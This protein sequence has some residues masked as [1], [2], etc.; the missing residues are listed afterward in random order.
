MMT[1]LSCD[2]KNACRSNPLAAY[3]AKRLPHMLITVVCL[4]IA[5][6][7][8]VALAAVYTL[9][10]QLFPSAAFAHQVAI[11]LTLVSLAAGLSLA[12]ELAWMRRHGISPESFKR[13]AGAATSEPK[14]DP[15]HLENRVKDLKLSTM[16]LGSSSSSADTWRAC[17]ND[18]RR[19]GG[20]WG[21]QHGSAENR[22]HAEHLRSLEIQALALADMVEAGCRS[23]EEKQEV[24]YRG[25]QAGFRQLEMSRDTFQRITRIAQAANRTLRAP[26]RKGIEKK[27]L[28]KRNCH[29]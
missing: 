11:S 16:P 7:L 22:M 17:V 25:V 24:G 15:R 20:Y 29:P 10:P 23:L 4:N 5:N 6:L 3:V 14:P 19:W 2:Q 8:F 18:L 1:N 9:D 13:E 28:T 21:R 27:N 26:N 12:L